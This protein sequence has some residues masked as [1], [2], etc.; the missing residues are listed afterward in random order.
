MHNYTNIKIWEALVSPTDNNDTLEC[1]YGKISVQVN[2]FEWW[3]M[4]QMLNL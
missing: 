2:G 3:L 4:L 1:T